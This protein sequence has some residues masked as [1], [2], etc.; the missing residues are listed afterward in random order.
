MVVVGAAAVG[1]AIFLLRHR[2]RRFH[3]LRYGSQV[4]KYAPPAGM[5]LEFA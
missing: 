3:L 1:S 4:P 2:H 5:G